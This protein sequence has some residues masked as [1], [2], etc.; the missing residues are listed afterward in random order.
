MVVYNVLQKA[1]LDIYHGV[2]FYLVCD[3]KKIMFTSHVLF[4]RMMELE[5]FISVFL[6]SST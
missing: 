3:K 4:L 2:E 5:T 1:N 6:F